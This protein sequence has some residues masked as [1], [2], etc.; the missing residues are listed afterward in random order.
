MSAACETIDF[1]RLSLEA[2]GGPVETME[3]H[4]SLV[5]IGHDRV[6]KLKR[7]VHYPYLDFSTPENRLA[8]CRAEID[9]NRRTA[10]KLY[11]GAKIITRQSDGRLGFDA[12]GELVDA[13]VEMRRFEQDQLFDALARSGRLSQKIAGDLA[14][15]IARF[16]DHAAAPEHPHGAQRIGDV[17][18]INDRSLRSSGIFTAA[19]CDALDAKFR[20]AFERHSRLLD[21]RAQQG[22]V[23]R[24][25]G[26]LTLRN[27]CMFEGEPTPFDC[28]EFNAELA[29][30]DV[31]YDLAFLLMDLWHRDQ[32]DIANWCFNRYLDA[33]DETDGLALMPLFMAMRACVRAH[34]TASQALGAVGDKGALIDEARAYLQI[35]GDFL[36]TP[37][38]SLVAVGGL[39]GSGKS[40][41]AAALAGKVG[42]APGARVLSSDRT[43]KQ[44]YGVSAT[45]RLPADAYAPA[46][47]QRVYETLFVNCRRVLD[48]GGS[49]IVEAVFD[50]AEDRNAMNNIANEYT[51]GFHG[52]WLDTA[53]DLA[54]QRILTRRDDP[55]D[56]TVDVLTGQ[57]AR[58]CGP[59]SWL[60]IDASAD[61]AATLA[62]ALATV[63]GARA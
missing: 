53:H 14:A 41:L 42:G 47:S 50:R 60:R 10:P 4:A 63:G 34:V 13:V 24:C 37:M 57:A 54:A 55:S 5:F 36:A 9:L 19:Q 30:I 62:K 44:I 26:D 39:S 17:L 61:A 7:P 20:S 29:T 43:R 49:C 25:H 46:V 40:T 28:L 48:A 2:L 21:R 22:K 32:R 45:T 33:R 16:H 3:T 23:R 11:L 35:A 52:L 51:L 38:Q 15:R 8:A 59:I 12:D 1:L 18:A 58:D 31:L 27:I 6:W 56:A